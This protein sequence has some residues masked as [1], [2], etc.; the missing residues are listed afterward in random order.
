[1]GATYDFE[2]LLRAI[3]QHSWVVIL[4]GELIILFGGFESTLVVLVAEVI[5]H[6][7][8]LHQQL[9]QVTGQFERISLRFQNFIEEKLCI[10]S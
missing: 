3:R 6:V 10:V 8:K 5:V 4:F 1:M 9:L 2:I 7:P